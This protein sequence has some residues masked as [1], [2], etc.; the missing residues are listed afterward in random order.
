M[1]P[2]SDDNIEQ[3]GGM[4]HAGNSSTLVPLQLLFCRQLITIENPYNRCKYVLNATSSE[5]LKDQYLR[6]LEY[7]TKGIECQEFWSF[8]LIQMLQKSKKHL[9]PDIFELIELSV[10]P[11]LE[12]RP[13]KILLTYGNIKV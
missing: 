12:C 6:L 11:I 8:Q 10:L 4:S 9:Y 13:G 7:E 1:L 5:T 2:V 3:D